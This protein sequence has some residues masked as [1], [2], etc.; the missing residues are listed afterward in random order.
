LNGRQKAEA[1]AAAAAVLAP[2]EFLPLHWQ[3]DRTLTHHRQQQVQPWNQ[4]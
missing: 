3:K 1:V 2:G 4:T